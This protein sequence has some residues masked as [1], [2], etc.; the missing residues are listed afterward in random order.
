[1]PTYEYRCNACGHEFV[2]VHTI[3]EHVKAKLTCP[4]CKSEEVARRYSTFFAKTRKKS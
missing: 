3:A 1:M 4:K 2:E